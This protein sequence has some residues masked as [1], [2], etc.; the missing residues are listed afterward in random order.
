MLKSLETI[1]NSSSMPISREKFSVSEL[2][3]HCELFST[4]PDK[5]S[6]EDIVFQIKLFDQSQHFYLQTKNKEK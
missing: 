1:L 3:L 6:Q 5:E 2:A 4:S